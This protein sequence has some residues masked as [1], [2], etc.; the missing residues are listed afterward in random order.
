[1]TAT[2]KK[3]AVKARTAKAAQPKGEL[4]N[5]SHKRDFNRL[6]NDAIGVKKK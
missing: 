5:P 4:P 3:R 1:M 2:K 6:L